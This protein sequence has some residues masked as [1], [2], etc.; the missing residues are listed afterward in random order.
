VRLSVYLIPLPTHVKVYN[1]WF[2]SKLVCSVV[3]SVASVDDDL[4]A[5]V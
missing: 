2:V 1:D 5:N 4:A 3:D